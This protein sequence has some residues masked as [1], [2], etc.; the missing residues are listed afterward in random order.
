MGSAGDVGTAAVG[1]S[2]DGS[3]GRAEAG[4]AEGR[5]DEAAGAAEGEGNAV[6]RMGAVGVGPAAAM[7]GVRLVAVAC[8]A[9]ATWWMACM[10]HHGVYSPA[11]T[12]P[13][14]D[15]RPYNFTDWKSLP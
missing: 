11:A 7:Q 13:G 2:N 12:W 10:V 9:C 15:G 14:L 6:A 8:G 4:A 1:G 5:E 3:G